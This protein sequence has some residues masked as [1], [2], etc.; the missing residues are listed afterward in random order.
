MWTVR[1]DFHHPIQL[2]VSHQLPHGGE[3]AASQKCRVPQGLFKETLLRRHMMKV[4]TGERSFACVVKECGKKFISHKVIHEHAR[5]HVNDRRS[6]ACA[7]CG[8]SW[9]SAK[10]Y[11]HHMTLHEIGYKPYACDICDRKFITKGQLLRH[12]KSHPQDM[13]FK[14]EL[15]WKVFKFHKTLSKHMK[16][17]QDILP[18]VMADPVDPEEKVFKC[19]QCERVLS[20]AKGLSYH[21]R[22]RHDNPKDKKFICKDCGKSWMRT[23]EF[24]QAISLSLARSAKND[25]SPK[26]RRKHTSQ[27]IRQSS[28]LSA[29]SAARVLGWKAGFS[30]I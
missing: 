9:R 29:M 27:N 14:C 5:T 22:N 12:M 28:R 19:D 15:C 10:S 8:E 20:S 30:G 13:W 7:E 11:S 4:H 1:Q 3:W 17:H 6:Y 23:W 18:M 2:E 16:T 26:W 21:K 24:I 25:L